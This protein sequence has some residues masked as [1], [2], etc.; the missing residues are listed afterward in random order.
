MNV[1]K[2]VLGGKRKVVKLRM[3]NV[4]AKPAPQYGSETRGPREEDRRRIEA[5]E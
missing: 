4:T 1:L 2:D 3:H 5:F